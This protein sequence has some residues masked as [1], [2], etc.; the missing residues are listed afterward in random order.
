M[1]RKIQVRRGLASAR[2]TLSAGEFGLDTDTGSEKVWVGTASGNL[3]LATGNPKQLLACQATSQTFSSGSTTY[4]TPFAALTGTTGLYRFYFRVAGTLANLNVW[5]VGNATISDV[6]WTVMRGVGSG[7]SS[8]TTITATLN[9]DGSFQSIAD[10]THSV[11]IAAGDWIEVRMVV[12]AAGLA[13]STP[14]WSL[15]FTPT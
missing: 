12:E 6:T 11:S 4:F 7:A 5:G 15:E 2:P 8:A 9:P 1:K 14:G 3:Q 10:T 13:Y